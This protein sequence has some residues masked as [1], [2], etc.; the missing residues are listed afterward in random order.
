[1]PQSPVGPSKSSRTSAPGLKFHVLDGARCAGSCDQSVIIVWRTPPT[2]Q[3]LSDLRAIVIE[4]LQEYPRGIG[5]LGIAEPGMPMLG[6]AE[7]K[8]S[9]DL[10]ALFGP[11]FRAIAT[12]IEG[13]GF[14]AGATQ[15]VMTAISLIARQPCPLR[16]F[17]S[18]GEALAWYTPLV[19]ADGGPGSSEALRQAIEVI[20]MHR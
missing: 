1:M 5:I 11:R 3:A 14:W 7:R 17:R 8:V 19:S 4:Q 6:A 9:G 15:S 12:V 18:I 16:I 13:H 2:V 20:R 10:L